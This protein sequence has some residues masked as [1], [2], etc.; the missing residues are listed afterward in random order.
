MKSFQNY[1]AH[2]V[3][4]DNNGYLLYF[5]LTRSFKYSK[6]VLIISNTLL[7][8]VKEIFT[9]GWYSKEVDLTYFNPCYL[10]NQG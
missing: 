2:S 7:I 5:T 9:M 10:D 3:V 1:F 4:T 6:G 8:L